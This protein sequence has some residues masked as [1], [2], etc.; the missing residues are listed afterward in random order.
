MFE[1]HHLKKLRRYVTFCVNEKEVRPT[2]F[3]NKYNPYHRKQSTYDL[4]KRAVRDKIIF[5]PRLLCVPDMNVEF[6]KFEGV[7]RV[8]L[9]KEKLEDENVTYVLALA[10]AYSLIYFEY[11][12]RILNYVECTTPQYP[13]SYTFDNLDPFKYGKGKLP[14]MAKPE[15]WS[16]LHWDV[17]KARNNPRRSSVEVGEELNVTAATVLNYFYE[18]LKDCR[19][20]IPFFP[21]GY[22]NY[23]NYVVTLK[24]NY[25]VGLTKELR[26]LDRSSYIY[27]AGDVLILSL[28]FDRYLEI[29]SF[30]KMEKEGIIHDLRVSFPVRFKN[31]FYK[32]LWD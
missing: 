23:T 1:P 27:K 30:L 18:I 15:R 13:S 28:F 20:W 6:V 12:K 10:G 7:P 21:N 14:E 25:E 19:I 16:N 11:G 2:K 3:H 8:D 9:Y 24:T 4:I 22:L 31:I 29:E 17:Y 5:E 26:K 32:A